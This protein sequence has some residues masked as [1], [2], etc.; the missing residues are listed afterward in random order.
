MSS[1]LL[2]MLTGGLAV[3]AWSAEPLRRAT[4]MPA[5]RQSRTGKEPDV[6]ERSE[7][8]TNTGAPSAIP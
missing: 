8:L 2:G 4:E 3:F 5:P 1:F 7:K 6:S